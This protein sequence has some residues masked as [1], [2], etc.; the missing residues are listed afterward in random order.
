[1]A[2]CSSCGKAIEEGSRFCSECGTTV[3]GIQAATPAP[4]TSVVV[5]KPR[6]GGLLAFKGFLT[7]LLLAFIFVAAAKNAFGLVIAFGIGAAYIIISLLSWKRSKNIVHGAGIGWTVAVFLLLVCFVGFMGA[8]ISAISKSMM[9]AVR[10][11]NGTTIPGIDS[12]SSGDPTPNV[13]PKDALLHR[14]KLDF[15]WHTDG[16][17]N[18][19][20][21]NF[22]IKNPTQYRFKDFEIKCTHSA[23]SGTVIDSNSRT[24]YQTVEPTSTKV[25]R[26]MNMGFINSQATRSGCQITDLVVLQ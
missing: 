15:K 21:A 5:V 7:A 22:T 14:V 25:I 1:M 24:I 13:D 23:P 8:G 11:A 12:T 20:M 3:P 4:V 26:E 16:F 2:Y 18:I 10:E 6:S 17:G 19:M 9:P